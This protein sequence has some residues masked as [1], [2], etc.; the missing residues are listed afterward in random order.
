MHKYVIDSLF[1][2]PEDSD[3]FSSISEL[4]WF[5]NPFAD[6]SPDR[7]DNLLPVETGKV[8]SLR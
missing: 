5:D 7:L 4:S 8:I 2:A 1:G 3:S 6:I